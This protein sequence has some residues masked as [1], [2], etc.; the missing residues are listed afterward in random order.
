MQKYCSKCN[1]E[2]E[3]NARF[4]SNCGSPE[5][6]FVDPEATTVLN[7][8]IGN[9]PQSTYNQ[10]DYSPQQSAQPQAPLYSQQQV[11]QFQQAMPFQPPVA[12]KKKGLK[13]WQIALIVVGIFALAGIGFIAEKVFQQ[14]GYGDSP[15][16][17]T[18]YFSDDNNSSTDDSNNTATSKTEYTKGTLSDDGIYTNEWANIKL[19]V[20]EGYTEGN[21]VNYNSFSDGGTTECGLYLVS[22]QQEMFA[23]TFV[24]A[25]SQKFINENIFLSQLSAGISQQE[26]ENVKY[27]IPEK[28]EDITIAGKNYVVAH[29]IISSYGIDMVQSYYVRKIGDRFCC[30]IIINSTKE[31]NNSLVSNIIPGNE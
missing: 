11:P 22:P 12:P 17:Q 28:Y 18:S 24:D 3:E 5:F 30:I 19:T 2:V 27:T 15:K 8:N 6:K 20:P 25:S 4:C 7:E 16:P 13:G 21:S 10:P 29:Y 26:I 1:C 9:E 23:I 31:E 14:Q